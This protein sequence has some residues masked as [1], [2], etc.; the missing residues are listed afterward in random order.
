MLRDVVRAALISLGLTCALWL[1]G[2]PLLWA[3][4]F[5]PLSA[6]TIYLVQLLRSEVSAD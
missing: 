2:V 1:T 6:P 3:I 4:L 5:S